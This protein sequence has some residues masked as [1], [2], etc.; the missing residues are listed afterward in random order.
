MVGEQRSGPSWSN[1]VIFWV[2]V[3]STLVYVLALVFLTIFPARDINLFR[4]VLGLAAEYWGEIS[5]IYIVAQ[6]LPIA[7]RPLNKDAWE[8]TDNISSYLPAAL[9]LIGF[10]LAWWGRWDLLSDDMVKI[11][12]V[13]IPIAIAD[14]LL[15]Q[16][17]YRIS[18]AAQRF[19]S[20]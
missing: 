14:V 10:P 3:L 18:R 7:T 9:L 11:I 6:V 4:G 15:T 20:A 8:I 1:R 12:Q 13:A 17:S 16:V 2:G 19:T 5:G